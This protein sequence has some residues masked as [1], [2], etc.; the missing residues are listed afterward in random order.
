[1]TFTF[2]MWLCPCDPSTTMHGQVPVTCHSIEMYVAIFCMVTFVTV[3]VHAIVTQF[4]QHRF[5]NCVV[6][7]RGIVNSVVYFKT[8]RRLTTPRTESFV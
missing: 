8:N 3:V 4:A 2:N 5:C 1:M 7:Q 6:R